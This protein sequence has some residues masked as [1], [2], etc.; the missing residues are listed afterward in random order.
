MTPDG[1][2]CAVRPCFVG[3]GDQDILE[4]LARHMEH[5]ATRQHLHH[6][7]ECGLRLVGE[8]LTGRRTRVVGRRKMARNLHP[9]RNPLCGPALQPQHSPG[10][11]ARQ[12][13]RLEF[14]ALP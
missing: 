1:E 10:P 8:T 9:A 12:T 11:L 14:V 5:L 7:T 13:L 2:H 3:S 6:R 4:V